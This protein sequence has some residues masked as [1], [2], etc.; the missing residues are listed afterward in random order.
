MVSWSWKKIVSVFLILCVLITGFS[1]NYLG[2]HTPQ[3]VCVGLLESALALIVM[4]KIS[5]LI[6]F[7]LYFNSISLC[8]VWTG[9]FCV[10]N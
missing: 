7:C 8:V 3:D 5:I 9:A 4:M 2:V 1:R 10:M 6:F